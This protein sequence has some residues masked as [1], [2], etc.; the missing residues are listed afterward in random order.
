MR[1]DSFGTRGAQSPVRSPDG[2]GHAVDGEKAARNAGALWAQKVLGERFSHFQNAN[3]KSPDAAPTPAPG[4]LEKSESAPP[5]APTRERKHFADVVEALMMKEGH[6]PPAWA[7]GALEVFGLGQSMHHILVLGI[8]GRQCCRVVRHLCG[9]ISS[10]SSRG[11]CQCQRWL[12]GGVHLPRRV[13]APCGANPAGER[14]WPAATPQ[15][16]ADASGVSGVHC[17]WQGKGSSLETSAILI[18][19]ARD[20]AGKALTQFQQS[21]S[22]SVPLQFEIRHPPAIAGKV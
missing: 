2:E 12:H 21:M 14:R 16:Q 17:T 7:E 9:E 5:T 20:W 1:R 22:D 6:K 8:D 3:T 15:C 11:S 13:S 10:R 4:N 19:K 18:R